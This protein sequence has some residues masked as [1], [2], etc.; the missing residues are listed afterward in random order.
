MAI[1][2]TIRVG[3]RTTGDNG[4]VAWGESEAKHYLISRVIDYPLPASEISC[5]VHKMVKQ[6]E[7]DHEDAKSLP[8]V[9][10][11]IRPSTESNAFFNN[12][13]KT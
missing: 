13:R 12:R 10:G 2:I 5:A 6:L 4:T 8:P 1:E 9:S 3:E 7:K 11:S